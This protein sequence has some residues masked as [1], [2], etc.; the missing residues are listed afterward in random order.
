MQGA[1]SSQQG[2]DGSGSQSSAVSGC[3]KLQALLNKLREVEAGNT[4]VDNTQVVG[5]N[6]WA[7]GWCNSSSFGCCT[8]RFT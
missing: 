2:A 6:A 8:F 3:S 4:Q 1:G 5:G 7:Q